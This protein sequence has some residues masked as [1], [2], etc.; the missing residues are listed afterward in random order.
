MLGLQELSKL[1]DPNRLDDET[2][3][4]IT[5][6]LHQGK[7]LQTFIGS[8]VVASDQYGGEV[9]ENAMSKIL[10]DYEDSVFKDKHDGDPP[11]RGP[12][13]EATIDVKPE[14]TSETTPS[15]LTGTRKMCG[16]TQLAT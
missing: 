11:V 2:L 7:N 16:R 10:K 9:V 12:H 13:G 8:V 4:E 14:I 3:K 1:D 5:L 6:Q 15:L